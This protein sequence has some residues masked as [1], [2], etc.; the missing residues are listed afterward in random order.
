MDAN[1]PAHVPSER[2]RD[3]DLYN[4]PG[5]DEDVHLAWKK[6]QDENPDVFYTPR[7]GGYWVVT[8]AALLERIWPDHEA[9]SSRH[10]SIPRIEGAPPQLPLEADPPVHQY[11]RAPVSVALSPKAVRTLTDR[12]RALAIEL[13]EGLRP[14]GRCD[15]VHEFAA[16]LPMEIFLSIVDLPS[17]DR[18]WLI[19]RAQ[20]MTRGAKVEAKQQALGEIFGYLEKWIGQ[21]REHPGEDLI[22]RIL[23]IRVADRPISHQEALSECALVLFGGL[24]TVAGTMGFIARFL[25][26]NPGHR[27][28]LVQEPAL[29]G[30]AIEELLRRHSI[31]TIAR[32]LTRDVTL[33]GVLMKAGDFVQLTTV[34]HGLDERAWP[35]PLEVDFERDAHAHMAFGKGVH[36]C[37]GSN[38]ARAEIRVFLEEWLKR[39]PQFSIAPGGDAV[40]ATGAVAGVLNLPLVWP[41]E[42]GPVPAAGSR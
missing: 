38:L 9:F 20:I 19:A 35:E 33:D 42:A 21:R 14:K 27:R 36:K 1:I 16:H 31:P 4:L 17:E 41:T 23:Q 5:A 12:A 13:I 8:R 22:S 24:D 29:I 40:T 39:I 34:F 6:V 26:R 25:A 37:P 32:V 10:I 15:F 30:R 11:F 2:V 3:V 28:R 18:E 7:Y